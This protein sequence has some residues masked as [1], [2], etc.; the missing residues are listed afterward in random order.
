[1]DSPGEV[2]VAR[3]R[4]PRYYYSTKAA[5]GQASSL[6][7]NGGADATAVIAQARA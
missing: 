6:K 3:W 4:G 2:M 7:K 1:M 5:I